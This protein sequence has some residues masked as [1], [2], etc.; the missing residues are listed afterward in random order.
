M[1]FKVGDKVKYIADR[2]YFMKGDIYQIDEIYKLHDGRYS[3]HLGR[4]AGSWTEDYIYD[5]FELVEDYTDSKNW[6][7][8]VREGHEELLGENIVTKELLNFFDKPLKNSSGKPQK[9]DDGKPRMDLIRPEFLIELGIALEYGQNK[10]NEQIGEV[11]NYL[12]GKG[13]H[14]TRLIGSTLRHFTKWCSGTR[15][16]EESGINHLILAAVNIMFLFT[17]D[18]SDKGIDDRTFLDSE[19]K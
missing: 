9:L 4:E 2:C 8:Y 15:I 10:Y 13:F 19:E 18:T 17:Y 12:K 7:D 16:D 14:Y 1:K 6:G 3:Y 11:P 5:E